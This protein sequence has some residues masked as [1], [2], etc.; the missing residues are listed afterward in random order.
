MLQAGKQRFKIFWVG[1]YLIVINVV[2]D[3]L[4]IIKV[5][6]TYKKYTFMHGAA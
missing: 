6:M 1:E 5:E 4:I 3:N 2:N